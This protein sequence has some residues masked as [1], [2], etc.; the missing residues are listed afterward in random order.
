MKD[1]SIT[2][3][4]ILELIYTIIDEHNKLYSDELKM[5]KSL[6]TILVGP[7]GKLDSLGLIT[8]L[9]DVE[10]I[11]KKNIDQNICVIDE[12][13]FLDENGPYRNVKNLS[14]YIFKKINEN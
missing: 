14:D 12:I 9:V 8:F 3:D 6:N 11:I 7:E 4:F 5:E 1:K 2:K 13:L 10:S